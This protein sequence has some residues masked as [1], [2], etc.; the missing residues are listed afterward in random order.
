[1]NFQKAL[2]CPVFPN[3]VTYGYWP[4]ALTSGDALG[5]VQ[6]AVWGVMLV[7][8]CGGL[9]TGYNFSCVYS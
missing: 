3:R 8:A 6:C 9:L 2:L 7:E 5:S 1:M 4:Y